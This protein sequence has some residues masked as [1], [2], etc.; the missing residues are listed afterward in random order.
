MIPISKIKNLSEN[1]QKIINI[2]QKNELKCKISISN[3]NLILTF[4][5]I[6]IEQIADN[7]FR[8]QDF[9]EIPIKDLIR[10]LKKRNM[11]VLHS[12][13]GGFISTQT[14]D[15]VFRFDPNFPLWV[16]AGLLEDYDPKEKIEID[17]GIDEKEIKKAMTK[18]NNL[19]GLKNIKQ[20]VDQLIKLIKYY[21]E[22]GQNIKNRISLH[23]VFTGNPGSGKTTV[24]RILADI[25]KAF[26]ILEK[27]HLIEV[28][29]AGLIGEYV[30]HTAT[31]TK[32]VIN[33]AL[34]GVLFIDE[35]YALSNKGITISVKKQLK[36]Y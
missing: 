9:Q 16:K 30:G 17:F 12:W 21:L 29:R 14:G 11:S 20:E 2:I 13:C 18:L 25:Y 32:S 33:S 23:S 22:T 31:K 6:K 3:E 8:T 1:Q 5:K 28:D 4:T 15:P 26:G 34:G 10:I 7:L 36:L 24:A 19:I 27:G 35:A